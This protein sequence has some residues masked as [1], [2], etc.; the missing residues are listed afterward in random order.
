V[1]YLSESSKNHRLG[2]DSRL[3]EIS[4]L[5]ITLTHV[6]FG[7][8]SSGGLR[9]YEQQNQLF[10]QGKSRCDGYTLKSKH[11]SGLA[12]DFYAFVNGKASWD[13]NHLTMVAAAFLEAGHRLDYKI[14]WGG[15]WQHFKDMPHIQLAC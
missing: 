14:E 8:P 6:D 2:V 13:E 12:L 5:A 1:F 15:F 7:H 10:H 9:T 11:Q 3:I 4:D